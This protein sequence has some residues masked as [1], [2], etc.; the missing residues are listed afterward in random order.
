MSV[1]GYNAGY[2]AGWENKQ[3]TV[4]HTNAEHFALH[5]NKISTGIGLNLQRASNEFCAIKRYFMK[6]TQLSHT[7]SH[8]TREILSDIHLGSYTYD[9]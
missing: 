3:F 5:A 7:D 2:N 6:K 8:D 1:L 9:R 4:I